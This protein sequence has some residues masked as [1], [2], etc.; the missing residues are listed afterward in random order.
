M[1]N[2]LST[3]VVS[4]SGSS[5]VNSIALLLVVLVCCAIL[6]GLGVWSINAFKLNPGVRKVWDGIFIFIGAFALIN[7]LLGL[8]GHAFIS[9]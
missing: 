6:Y 8:T 4:G 7:F 5:F 9:W 1:K 3:V 2:L